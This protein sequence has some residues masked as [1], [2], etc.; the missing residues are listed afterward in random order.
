[1]CQVPSYFSHVQLFCNPMDYSPPGSSVLG[2]FQARILEGVPCLPSRDLPNPE[3][4]KLHLLCLLH[5]QADSLPLS[6][7]VSPG[8]HIPEV[9][10]ME[11]LMVHCL[12]FH[13]VNLIVDE[14]IPTVY[15]RV[16]SKF[17]LHII[18]QFSSVTQSC[19]TLCDPMNRSTPG[20]PVHHQLPGLAE[21]HVH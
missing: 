15:S 20:L 17:C 1:M 21:T 16:Q 13:V 18:V 7:V 14:P 11:E 8:N 3:I 2:V 12:Q 10:I 5:W 6:H 4:L 9:K 19:P